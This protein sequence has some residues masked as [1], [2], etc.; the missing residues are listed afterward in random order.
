M[1]TPGL[2]RGDRPLALAPCLLVSVPARSMPPAV[3]TDPRTIQQTQE[4]LQRL[5][6]LLV[7]CQTDE[8]AH[9]DE[10]AAAQGSQPPGIVLRAWCAVV[11]FGSRAAVAMCRYL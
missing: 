9:R 8:I 6:A 3:A 7:L 5:R 2:D 1:S 4:F 11:G 10:A